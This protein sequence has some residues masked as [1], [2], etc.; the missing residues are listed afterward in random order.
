LRG[1]GQVFNIIHGNVLQF[2]DLGWNKTPAVHL[3]S[4]RS[5]NINLLND[6]ANVQAIY[7]AFLMINIFFFQQL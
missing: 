1:A 7:W 6:T 2:S 4:L 5:S 3:F